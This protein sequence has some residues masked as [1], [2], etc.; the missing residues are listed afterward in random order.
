MLPIYVIH[1][2]CVT[3][4]DLGVLTLSDDPCDQLCYAP[5]LSSFHFSLFLFSYSVVSRH[6][7]HFLLFPVMI[8]H[9]LVTVS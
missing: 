3:I 1:L 4:S 9:A 5:I 7:I 2:F 8:H 6:H